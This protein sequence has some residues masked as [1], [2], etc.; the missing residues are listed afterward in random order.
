V[1][2]HRRTQ[3]SQDTLTHDETRCTTYYTHDRRRPG[4]R[5]AGRAAAAAGAGAA[6]RAASRGT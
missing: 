3:K 6:L 1:S 2:P 4:A 5:R